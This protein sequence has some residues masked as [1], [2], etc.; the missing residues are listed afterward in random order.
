[1]QVGKPRPPS[2]VFILLIIFY[3]SSS[4]FAQE[5][6]P[7]ERLATAVA[8]AKNDA[9]RE[10]LLAQNGDKVTTQLRKALVAQADRLRKQ[11]A[12]QQA[13]EL[14]GFILKISEKSGDKMGTASAFNGIGTIRFQ[15]SEYDEAL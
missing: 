3:V 4:V 1:M 6:S 7:E 8:A 2:I 9:E 12:S 10:V 15:K 11:S 5:Q 13:L 14:Y